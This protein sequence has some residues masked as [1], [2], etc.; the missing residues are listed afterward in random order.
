VPAR[1]ELVEAFARAIAKPGGRALR[2]DAQNQADGWVPI[3]TAVAAGVAFAVEVDQNVL[4]VDADGA[5][6]APAVQ[7]LAD[8]LRHGGYAPVVVASGRPGHL[9][10]HCRIADPDV[11]YGAA[12]RAR[13]GGLDV[14]R[15]IR[16]PLAPHR[17]GLSVMLL[18]PEDPA[19]ALARLTRTASSPASSP[20]PEC[21][22][23]VRL[24][25]LLRQGD[26]DQRYRSRSEVVMA[27]ALAFV[28]AGLTL[29]DLVTV[30][31]DTRN[32]AGDKVREL[33]ARR[34]LP[35]ARRWVALAWA[36]A[37]VRANQYP[38]F[39]NGGDVRGEISRIRAA[40]KAAPWRGMAGGSDWAVLQAHLQIAERVDR[41]T[42]RA[43]AREVAELAGVSAK[44]ASKAHKRLRNRGWLRYAGRVAGPGAAF[45]WTLARPRHVTTVHNLLT[46]PE[47]GGRTVT[48]SDAW[49][50]AAG[51]ERARGLG[52]SAARVWGLLSETYYSTSAVGGALVHDLTGHLGV[53]AGAVRKQL[54]KLVSMGLAARARGRAGG[55]YRLSGDLEH[56]A[57]RLRV[58]GAGEAR[59]KQHFRERLA[60]REAP[61]KPG[62]S[63][64]AARDIHP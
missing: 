22:L 31:L 20:P 36:K 51:P 54:R 53:K 28:N 18:Q 49:V 63:L 10:L 46:P 58:A 11:R 35:A 34:G 45:R 27:L 26:R 32:A 19:V 1:L 41:L 43:S 48:G 29:G 50:W 56:V 12:A 16:P 15:V 62:A 47:G 64:P 38:A 25:A 5:E 30:L 23:S 37:E 61:V 8:S 3:H 4:S 24:R 40:A 2:L 55:W 44:T 6:V 33:A 39:R 60:Y 21:R 59:R 42:Y 17:L 52:K 57:L 9:H 7:A 13:E 14:R